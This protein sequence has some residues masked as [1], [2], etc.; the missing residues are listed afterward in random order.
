MNAARTASA[1]A[2]SLLDARVEQRVAQSRR[3]AA[4]SGREAGQ[5]EVAQVHDRRP[6]AHPADDLLPVDAPSRPDRYGSCAGSARTT[7]YLIA[8]AT[9]SSIKPADGIEP[10]FGIGAESIFG[11]QIED[12]RHARR[13]SDLPKA[14]FHSDRIAGIAAGQD[15]C[16]PEGVA[17]Q[18]ARLIH[19]AAERGP[20]ARNGPARRAEAR[21]PREQRFVLGERDVIQKGVAAVEKSADAPR[22]K[23]TGDLLGRIEVD[24]PAAVGLAGQWRD[25]EHAPESTVV[26]DS[27]MMCESITQDGGRRPEAGVEGRGWKWVL[28]L[29]RSG[30]KPEGRR[31]KR[32]KRVGVGPH[33]H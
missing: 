14:G 19:S 18:Q 20:D 22:F 9:P 6:L 29:P 16:A 17:A 7:A 12:E 24:A 27:C 33:A 28:R 30:G 32:V 11:L 4:G 26:T 31:A 13:L 2:Q 1:R 10:G 21:K 5:L 25:R 8:T 3:D 23:V 15:H